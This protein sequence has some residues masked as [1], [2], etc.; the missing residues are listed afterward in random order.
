M[1]AFCALQHPQV[2]GKSPFAVGLVSVVSGTV[3][4]RAKGEPGWLTR[5]YVESTKLPVR[6]YLEA[7]L[8]EDGFPAS[9]LAE[10]RRF[11]DVLQ[12]KGYTVRYSEF[13]GG[14]DYVTWR[15]M[16]AEGLMYLLS[17]D[18]K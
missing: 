6:F 3:W 4:F 14:H 11:R 1:S 10:N 7:G 16:F 17:A 9:L 12:A 13:A 2:F 15:G 8:Y 18:R 5:K